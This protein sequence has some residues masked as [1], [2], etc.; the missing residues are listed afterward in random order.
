MYKLKVQ[1]PHFSV[2]NTFTEGNWSVNATYSKFFK[3]GENRQEMEPH[4]YNCS[5]VSK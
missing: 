2:S 1:L 5:H 3:S 4:L